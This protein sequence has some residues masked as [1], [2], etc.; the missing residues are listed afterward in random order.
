MKLAFSSNAY[1][2]F[3]IEATLERIA[4]LGYSGVEI[5]ADVPHVSAAEQ[6]YSL[7]AALFMLE[8]NM[9]QLESVA[10]FYGDQTQ[11]RFHGL[12]EGRRPLEI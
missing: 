4:S 6:R 10:F 1:L 12:R 2:H 3:S 5:L 11:L 9:R 8:V 7:E